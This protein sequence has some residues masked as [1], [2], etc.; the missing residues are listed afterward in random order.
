VDFVAMSFVLSAADLRQARAA[1]REAGAPELP[2]VA[3]LERP[4]AIEALDEILR[5]CDAVMVARG[6]L[7]LEVPLE[8][9][10]RVQKAICLR[11]RTL[12]VPVIVATQVFESMIKEPRPTR[13][14]VSDAANAA[15]AGVDAIMLAGETAVGQFPIRAV[16]T[17]DA[18]IREA[19]TSPVE[20]VPLQGAKLLASHG[21]AICEAAVTLASRS[22]AAAIVAITRRG[23]TARLLSALRPRVPIYAATD[24]PA[25]ARRLALSWGV[26]PV[27][28]SL[29]GDVSETATRIGSVLTARSAIPA[30]ATVVLVSITP[31]LAPGPSNF[32]KL[33]RV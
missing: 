24:D 29:R 1:L 8:S 31:D 9:V 19:E 32:L 26:V 14:E 27:V 12:G 11:A 20:V 3:K 13:A 5:A 25:I 22:E 17:L 2:L 7:G 33:Q 18:I 23:K 28:A 6:D 16:Q 30:A 4:E 15:R 10:P 21:R